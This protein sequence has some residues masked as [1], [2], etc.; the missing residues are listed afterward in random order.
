MVSRT[1]PSSSLLKP[2]AAS[3]KGSSIVMAP[4]RVPTKRM[5]ISAGRTKS[6]NNNVGSQTTQTAAGR[7]TNVS[8][9]DRSGDSRNIIPRAASYA[10]SSSGSSATNRTGTS[11]ARSSIDSTSSSSSQG[12]RVFPLNGLQGKTNRPVSIPPPGVKSRIPSRFPLKGKNPPCSS[13]ISAKL[14]ASVLS[15]S[16]SPTSSISEWSSSSSTFTANQEHKVSKDCSSLH[17]T[18]SLDSNAS[19]D[20]QMHPNQ[21]AS[22]ENEIEAQESSADN[23]AVSNPV[24]AKPSGLRMPSPKIGFFDGVKSGGRSQNAVG[25]MQSRSRLSNSRLPRSTSGSS[26][27]V[28]VPNKG[29]IGN[30]TVKTTALAAAKANPDTPRSNK[31]ITAS[32]GRRLEGILTAPE[33]ESNV[34]VSEDVTKTTSTTSLKTTEENN[35]A[36]AK[37]PVGEKHHSESG[38]SSRKKSGLVILS[39][40]AT[41]EE[42]SHFQGNQVSSAVEADHQIMEMNDDS[43]LPSAQLLHKL[44]NG[45]TVNTELHPIHMSEEVGAVEADQHIMEM[46]DDSEVLSAQLLHESINGDNAIKGD[47]NADTVLLNGSNE[48]NDQICAVITDQQNAFAEQQVNGLIVNVEAVDNKQGLCNEMNGRFEPHS[49]VNSVIDSHSPA[50]L[51]KQTDL[52][53]SLKML[54]SKPGARTPLADKNSSPDAYAMEILLKSFTSLSLD[55]L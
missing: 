12:S 41:P 47:E 54:E 22:L 11:S 38:S 32:G 1:E 5:S 15:P 29:R 49:K 55:N 35:S 40:N 52:S 45:D 7:V 26:S 51:P 44:I 42:K 31:R 21:Q 33:K 46:N 24:S 13:R 37:L 25:S 28:G 10:K 53:V 39:K 48:K 36:V 34:R 2:A 19:Q 27:P 8:K 14:S 30:A 6:D 20:L 50:D 16:V 17:R 23:A 3:G 43:K 18:F 9:G 4:A